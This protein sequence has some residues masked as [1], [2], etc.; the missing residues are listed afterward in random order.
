MGVLEKSMKIIE[1]QL[2]FLL[3]FN[4]SHF[5]TFLN[6][7]TNFESFS[8]KAYHQNIKKHETKRKGK[9]CTKGFSK[10]GNR[11]SDEKLFKTEEK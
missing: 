5:S 6:L 3:F 2:F 1:K 11:E 4:D 9:I 10:Q 8:P 7:D